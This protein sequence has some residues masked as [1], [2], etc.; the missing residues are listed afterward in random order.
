MGLTGSWP[1]SR[2]RQETSGPVTVAKQWRLPQPLSGFQGLQL[3]RRLLDPAH[4]S[5]LIEL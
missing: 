3:L 5:C 4:G 1:R 2:A